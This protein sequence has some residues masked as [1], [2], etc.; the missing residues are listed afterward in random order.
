MKDDQRE[1]LKK[2]VS[3]HLGS[4]FTEAQ[5]YAILGLLE[6]FHDSFIAKGEKVSVFKG[7]NIP[8]EEA[9]KALGYK[10]EKVQAALNLTPAQCHHCGWHGE[11]HILKDEPTECPLCGTCSLG[12]LT[13]PFDEQFEGG[14]K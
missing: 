4:E 7:T 2:F 10:G 12:V 8:I 3:H 11:T 9:A 14:V 13:E 6:D 5:H 1:L